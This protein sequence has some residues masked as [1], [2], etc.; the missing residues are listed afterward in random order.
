[1]ASKLER[2]KVPH[3]YTRVDKINRTYNGKLDRK[4]YRE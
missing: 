1:M 4:S 2:Y 3:L